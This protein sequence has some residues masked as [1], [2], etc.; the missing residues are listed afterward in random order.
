MVGVRMSMAS[1]YPF[2]SVFLGTYCGVIYY[3]SSTMHFFQMSVLS[4]SAVIL[5]QH[6]KKKKT[7]VQL[8][9]KTLRQK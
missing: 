8:L 1:L 4:T 6:M 7:N 2:T 9:S 3:R 5:M